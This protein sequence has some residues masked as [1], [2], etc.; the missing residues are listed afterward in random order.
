MAEVRPLDVAQHEA[1]HVVVGAA[2]GLRLQRAAIGRWQR[3]PNAV[4][5]AWFLDGTGDRE[6]QAMM[7]AA[8]V[9][10][11]RGLRYP[12]YGYSYDAR[13]ARRLCSGSTGYKAILRA[14]ATLLSH[15]MPLHRR[16]TRALLERDIRHGDLMGIARGDRD[17]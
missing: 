6:A 4:G 13:E 12:K 16:V 7:L 3:D 10:W 1:A 5:Y 8:G 9:V 2:L 17:V 11:D 15:L 14:S